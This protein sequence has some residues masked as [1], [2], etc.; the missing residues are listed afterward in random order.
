MSR[1]RRKPFKKR[2]LKIMIISLLLYIFQHPENWWSNRDNGG[3]EARK[4]RH[5]S[6][7]G[8]ENRFVDSWLECWCRAR[9]FGDCEECLSQAKLESSANG[10]LERYCEHALWYRTRFDCAGRSATLQV[11]ETICTASGNRSRVDSHCWTF[12]GIAHRHAHWTLLW[13]RNR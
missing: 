6:W 9:C 8:C 12:I 1:L 7:K 2:P 4:W 11:T 10:R 13:W 3:M 5:W